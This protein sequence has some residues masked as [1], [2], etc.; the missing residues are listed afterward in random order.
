MKEKIISI[1][2]T[3]SDGQLVF[4]WSDELMSVID[5]SSKQAIIDTIQQS[6][7]TEC[8]TKDSLKDC[9]F[10]ELTNWAQNNDCLILVDSNLLIC[11]AEKDARLL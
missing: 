7:T 3:L 10:A 1:I 9:G 11:L 6:A 4:Q 8:V 5:E 2:S